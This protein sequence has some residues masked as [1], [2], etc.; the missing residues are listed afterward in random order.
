AL[1]LLAGGVGLL[2]AARALQ[3]I[4]VGLSSGAAGA[5][6]LELR[7]A[8]EVAPLVSSAAPTGGQALGALGASALA[9][10]APAPAP[11]VS[12]LVL[13]ASV[14]GILAVWKM[15]EPGTPRPGW[16]ASLRPRIS[17]PPQVRGAF[18]TALPGLVSVWALGGLYLSLGPSLAAQLTHSGNV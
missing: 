7:P 15:P 16:P 5:A 14:A 11:L 18:F 3:G 9:Q 1:F 10:Y 12:L 2:F 17:V 4:A 8:G 6:L 13:V